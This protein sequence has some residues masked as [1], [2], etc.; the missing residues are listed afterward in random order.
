M[1]KKYIVRII[2]V[3]TIFSILATSG[4]SL[5]EGKNQHRYSADFLVLFNTATRMIGYAESEETFQ[6]QSQ[7]IYDRLE[8]YHQ[9]Y[10]R[11][12]TVEGLNNIR[13]INQQA[14]KTPVPVDESILDL[15]E[16]SQAAYEASNGKVNVMIG[17]VTDLWHNYRDRYQYDEAGAQLPSQEDLQ[18][19]AAHISMESLVLDREKGT[20]YITD[21][22]AQLDVG[23]I[24]KG[25][26]VQRVVDEARAY[27]ITNMLLSVGGNVAAIGTKFDNQGQAEN[28]SVGIQNPD[29]SNDEISPSLKLAGMS[30]VSS[31]AYERYYVYDG[32]A[33]GH[34]IDP[35]TLF[36]PR[37]YQQVTIAAQDSGQADI[38]STALF[39]M[40]LEE[41]KEFA[42]AQG[43]EALWILQDGSLVYTEGFRNYEKAK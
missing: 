27:G 2:S 31:G 35:E 29:G 18:A 22:D 6:D 25:Y 33:Y 26:A 19:A 41:G 43:I 8:F 7:F 39:I 34:I 12:E 13:T 30:L 10:N 17:A 16:I 1:N 5:Q 11:F 14:G 9:H 37:R 15:L 3:L 40:D 36:P 24:A 4:C 32:Q 28:W 21:P 20:A 23:A 42:K 38:C